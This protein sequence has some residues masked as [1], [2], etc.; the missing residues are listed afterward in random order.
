MIAAAVMAVSFVPLIINTADT[1]FEQRNITARYAMQPPS[2]MLSFK[3]RPVR[4]LNEAGIWRRYLP[5]AR[6]A[7]SG[8][9]D[10]SGRPAEPTVIS[11]SSLLLYGLLAVGHQ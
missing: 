2:L 8:Y 1:G 6:A 5:D 7:F 9:P 10:I 4:S 3:N 11:M